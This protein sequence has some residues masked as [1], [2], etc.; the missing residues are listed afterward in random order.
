MWGG[1]EVVESNAYQYRVADY[2]LA[3]ILAIRGD[4]Q[5]I[6]QDPAARDRLIAGI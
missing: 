6:P 3:L 1:E 5:E 4:D 2:A